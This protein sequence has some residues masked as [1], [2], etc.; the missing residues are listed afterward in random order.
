MYHTDEERE[1]AAR[2]S[3]L[4]YSRSHKGQHRKENMTPEAYRKF[5]EYHREYQRRYR[6]TEAGREVVRISH[7]QQATQRVKVWCHIDGKGKYVN[8]RN[9]VADILYKLEPSERTREALESAKQKVHG[10]E[11]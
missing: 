5:L 8:V 3:R 1:Q 9:E 4:K 2:D 7:R 6:K 10:I 11:G